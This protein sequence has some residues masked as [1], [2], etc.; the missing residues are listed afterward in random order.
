MSFEIIYPIDIRNFKLL[1]ENDIHLKFD[2]SFNRKKNSKIDEIVNRYKSSIEKQV[3]KN[4]Y[5]KPKF[6]LHSV[7]NSNGKPTLNIGMTDY[8]EYLITNHNSEINE[9]LVEIGNKEY[10]DA[11][12]F[13]SNALGNVSILLT[14]DGKIAL[15]KRSN[16]VQTFIGYNDLPGGHPEPGN[17]N[18]GDYSANTIKAE[19]F[20]SIKQEI[21]EELNIAE[22]HLIG[23]FNIGYLK[24]YEDGCKPEMIFYIP[25]NLTSEDI[26]TAFYEIGKKTNEAEELVFVDIDHL[27]EMDFKITTASFGALTFFSKIRKYL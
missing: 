7:I 22:D 20:N 26:H 21:W 12:A 14:L 11:D 27:G 1:D 6:R 17:I 24:S 13:L 16:Y 4:L 25:L 23:V 19:L 10:Q 18:P 3:N 15:L 9:F 2:T 8:Y 5:N